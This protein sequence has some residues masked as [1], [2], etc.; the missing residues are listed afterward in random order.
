MLWQDVEKEGQEG[1]V[2][3]KG[4]DKLAALTALGREKWAEVYQEHFT[5][6]INKT[7]METIEKVKGQVGLAVFF[8][9]MW[10]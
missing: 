7:S 6:G 8:L 2:L 10:V 9:V 5:T 3:S 4:E 1:V